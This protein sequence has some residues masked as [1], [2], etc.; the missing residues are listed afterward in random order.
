MG[1]WTTCAEMALGGGADASDGGGAGSAK[2]TIHGL[3]TTGVCLRRMHYQR[4]RQAC[5]QRR[6]V[7]T[8][9]G[10]PQRT[11]WGLA[12]LLYWTVGVVLV[13]VGGG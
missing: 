2:A 1:A 4:Q 8:R 11:R 9:P 12:E 10:C 13:L 3:A 6:N 5:R 7:A